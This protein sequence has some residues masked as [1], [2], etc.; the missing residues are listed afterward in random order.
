V[1]QLPQAERTSSDSACAGKPARNACKMCS[2]LGACLAFSGVEGMVPLLHGSQGCST[3]IRRYLI[4]HFREPMDIASSNF[5][6]QAA[7]FGGAENLKRALANVIK[8]YAPP[9]I[10][11]ATT[12]LSETI[13]DDVRRFLHE[14]AVDHAD[15]ASRIVH[16]STPAYAGTHADGYVRAVRAIVEQ[17][18]EGGGHRLGDVI[19]VYPG[20]VSPADLRHLRELASA[21]GLRS[22]IMPDYADRLDGGAWRDYQKTPPGG[23]SLDA[24]RTLG[25][26]AASVELSAVAADDDSTA[27]AW[28][29]E[30]FEV[31]RH[32]IAPPVGLRGSDELMAIL[33]VLSGRPI[34]ADL[35][36]E[37]GRLIDSYVDAHKYLFDRRVVLFGDEDSVI[38]LARFCVEVGLRPV[39]CG[40]GGTSGALRKHLDGIVDAECQVLGD[41]DFE[42]IADAAQA[43]QP[44]LLIGNSKG[45]RLA[46]QLGVP[47]VRVGLPVHDRIGASRIRTLGYAGTQQLFDRVVNAIL[48]RQQDESE[49]GYSY[50]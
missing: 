45:Y 34:P 24:I 7:I 25:R 46:R 16:A 38:G 15:A 20:L 31:P 33:S 35:D 48:E 30:R 41:V 17:L 27:A 49:I 39:L 23:T 43:A 22:V 28:L 40:S 50:L 14:F 5:G 42:D 26:S 19:G 2:P 9:A 47:L 11:V 1:I 18:A 44:D 21:F 4:S 10:G 29:Q 12:C 32:R 6:E 13:G 36:A 8:G 3:Y 37:R